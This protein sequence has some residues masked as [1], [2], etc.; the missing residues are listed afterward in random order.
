MEAL[1]VGGAAAE[2]VVGALVDRGI[3]V[4]RGGGVA[5]GIG[6]GLV[7]AHRRLLLRTL[8]HYEVK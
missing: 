5:G 7:F 3:A 8:A 1:R 2:A 6:R 4:H